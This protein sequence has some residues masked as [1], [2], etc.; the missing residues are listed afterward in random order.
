MRL[1]LLCKAL[2]AVLLVQS[3][4]IAHA[5]QDAEQKGL[6]DPLTLEHALSMADELHPDLAVMQA[7]VLSAE[8]ARRRVDAAT[9]INAYIE[10]R[11][12]YVDPPALSPTQSNDDHRLGL[13]IRKELYDFGRSASQ[14][15]AAQAEIAGRQMLYLDA[16]AQRRLQIMNRFFDVLLAD[17]N[18]LRYN[19]EMATAYVEWDRRQDRRELGQM[20]DYE[21]LEQETRYQRMRYLRYESMNQQRQTRARLAEALNR[22]GQLPANLVA[23]SLDMLQREIP[24][25]EDLLKAAMDNNYQLKALRAQYEAG[26]Q[27]LEVARSTNNARVFGNLE[28]YEYSTERTGSSDRFRAGVTVEIPVFTGDREDA[29]VASAR[30]QNFRLRA[31]LSKVESDIRQAVLETWLQLDAL[32]VQREEM[33]TLEV[34]R[35]LNLDRSRALYEMEVKADL[36]DAMVQI[37][38]AQY[39]RLQTDYRMA[40]AWMKMD[41]LTGQLGLEQNGADQH[42]TKSTISNGQQSEQ[43]PQ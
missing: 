5:E 34:F 25:Y 10:G 35:E 7:D 28:A 43:T 12:Q 15:N 27:R 1:G 6:P 33:Q 13:I 17:L 19:E 2:S 16:R 41:I 37:T 20:S 29:E 4:I 30:A 21:V 11:L 3:S 14:S 38:E 31:Q 32:R 8:A 40:L 39:L 23:P 42:E 22:P 24:E 18:F 9:D 36:G 26:Q